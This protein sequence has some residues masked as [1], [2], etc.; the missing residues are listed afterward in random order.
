MNGA[1]ASTATATIATA[2]ARPA[3]VGRFA[4]SPTGSLHLGSLVAAVGSFVEARSRGGRWL[5]RMED[6]DAPRVIPGCAD[7]MLRTLESFALHWDGAVEYQSARTRH[8]ARAL[9]TLIALGVTFECS[10]SRGERTPEGGYPGTCREGPKRRGPTATRFKV[11]DQLISFEDRAQGICRF[12]LRERGDVIIRRRDGAFAY[13]LAVVVDDALQAVTDVVRGADLLD[14]T[15]WQIALQGALG[16]TT[17]RYTHLPLVTEPGGAK[18][19]K[20]RRSVAL[21]PAMA[22]PQLQ[23]AL[24]LLGQNPPPKLKLESPRTVLEWACA[25]WDLDRFHGVREVRASR[26]GGF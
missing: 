18:L 22:G 6:L 19:A 8:Y 11:Q 3:C 4:P 10:C 16:L 14:S 20:S 13:Q 25:H 12:Q 5:L 7:Q 24:R 26:G 17:P 2:S 23:E 9:Q 21:D 1:S 15:P